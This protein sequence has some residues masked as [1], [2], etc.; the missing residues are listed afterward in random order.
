MKKNVQHDFILTQILQELREVKKQNLE[1]QKDLDLLI[2]SHKVV[3]SGD[4]LSDISPIDFTQSDWYKELVSISKDTDENFSISED[5]DEK[6]I[7]LTEETQK[8]IDDYE[9]EFGGSCKAND[10]YLNYISKFK[11]YFLGE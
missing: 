9:K 1:I 10:I 11:K 2:L 5:I 8:V 7:K 3:I 6:I 4:Y